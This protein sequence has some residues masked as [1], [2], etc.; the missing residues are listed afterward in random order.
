MGKHFNVTGTCIPS[1]H[2]MVNI[3]RKI[4]AIVRDYIQ[5]GSYFTM[6]RARQF[7]KTTTLYLLEERLKNNYI[8]LSLSFES[9]DDYFESIQNLVEG[10]IMD[11]SDLLYAQNIPGDIIEKWNAPVSP[12]F[13]LRTLGSRIT[14]LC[15]SC[16]QDIILIIDEVDKSS[17]N[18]IFLTFLGLL[19]EK[20]LRL[21]TGKDTTFK[22][23]ILA[24]VYDIK[25]LKL[26][27]HPSE[28]T[29]NNSP[30]NIAADFLLDM[31]FSPQ[32]IASML[33]Q[34]EADY[35]TGMSIPVFSQQIYDFTS[36][37]PYL[38]SRICQIIDERIAG[39]ASYPDKKSAWTKS[40][41]L[42]AIRILQKESNSLFEDMIKHLYEYPQL[43]IMLQ[44]I[45]FRGIRY[46]FE[47]NSFIIN[48]GTMFGFL[49]EE[50]NQ[51]IVA[52]RIFE[53]KL[54]N[55]FLSEEENSLSPIP[56]ADSSP[57][58][59]IS[60]GMLQMDLVMEKFYEYYE[61]ICQNSSEKFLEDE[62]RRIF[63]MFLRPIING[64]GN[65]YIEAQTRDKTRTDI[66]IDYRGQQFI[67]ELKIWKGA[68][69]HH[70]G[71]IQLAE[72]LE[73]FNQK[74]GYLLTFNFNKHKK[75]GITESICNGKHILEVTV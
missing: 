18:Q 17:D 58:Q 6:N 12:R 46:T 14:E 72:Y 43:S 9:A 74:K 52:N 63:L 37:Y 44:N 11:I 2:Y 33:Q 62:G 1:E 48:L 35:H 68:Q 73:H 15:K 22:S 38:V 10:L 67:I 13:P 50:N 69:Y 70:D 47:S 54:Y 45:L 25:N 65:Y 39:T 42:Y 24:G 30:W 32:E 7:G 41:F 55:F 59:F 66:I 40:G 28:E 23:V 75:T 57:S 71:R 29:K 31:S 56:M 16:S 5:T 34:Y 51:V 8:V 61:A 20:Y 3:D 21:K 4:D 36:G 19:R 26:K 49:K 27:L 64:T 60:H 53:T